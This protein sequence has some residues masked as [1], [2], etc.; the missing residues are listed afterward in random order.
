ML[1]TFTDDED[2]TRSG[3]PTSAAAGDHEASEE[4]TDAQERHRELMGRMFPQGTESA[5]RMAEQFFP[6]HEDAASMKREGSERDSREGSG[7]QVSQTNDVAMKETSEAQAEER[8]AAAEQQNTANHNPH[9]E[10]SSEKQS[11]LENRGEAM[12][13]EQ[14]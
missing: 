14:S 6:K 12:A 2:G 3:T 11:D 1:T 4:P 10:A 7:S 9:A 13:T 8:A 5:G